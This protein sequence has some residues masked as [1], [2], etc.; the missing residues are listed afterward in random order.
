MAD[1]YA[2]ALVEEVRAQLT[3]LE[4]IKAR[5][6]L[7]PS[8]PA[9]AKRL[10]P[11]EVSRLAPST[12]PAPWPFEETFE[13]WNSRLDDT[14][15]RAAT[16]GGVG[17]TFPDPGVDAAATAGSAGAGVVVGG[18]GG[19]EVTPEVALGVVPAGATGAARV[20]AMYPDL[21]K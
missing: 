20:R 16:A 3:A 5:H 8:P 6:A 18:V 7:P 21:F 1:T 17:A 11:G 12:A 13:R 4:G 9:P 15:I 10:G 2:E 14:A 19:P